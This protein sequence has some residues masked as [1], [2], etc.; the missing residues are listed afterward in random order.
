VYKLP[1]SLLFLKFGYRFNNPIQGDFLPPNLKNIQFG[2]WY[3]GPLTDMPLS[4][5]HISLPIA[6][7]VTELLPPSLT[8]LSFGTDS[9]NR[10]EKVSKPTCSLTN[11]EQLQALK[12]LYFHAYRPC[13]KRYTPL[14]PPSS[15]LRCFF[16]FF[17]FFF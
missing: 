4:L 9:E 8:H 14:S 10:G 3:Q 12:Y 11:Y 13:E 15:L 17:F 16:F 6:Y 5:T 1:P 2:S 7:Q